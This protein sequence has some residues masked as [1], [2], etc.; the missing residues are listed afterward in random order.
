MGYGTTDARGY[1]F[2]RAYREG[3]LPIQPA[4]DGRKL[5]REI[6]AWD[7]CLKYRGPAEYIR[8][9]YGIGG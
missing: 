4:E 5:A 6:R 3:V 8:R 9:R 2:A 1:V 7:R